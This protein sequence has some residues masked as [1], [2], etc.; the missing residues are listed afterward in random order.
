MR[1]A[2]A[3]TALLLA[4]CGA[5]IHDEPT[6]NQ[7]KNIEYES[8]SANE[9]NSFRGNMQLDNQKKGPDRTTLR[10]PTV[11][12]LLRRLA[13]K[14]KQRGMERENNTSEENK[15][16]PLA[17]DSDPASPDLGVIGNRYRDSDGERRRASDAASSRAGK[18]SIMDKESMR[19]PFDK[20]MEDATAEATS[21]ST[22]E[23]TVYEY[24]SFLI[25]NLQEICQEGQRFCDCENFDFE[26]VNGTIECNRFYGDTTGSD[27]C[28]STINYCGEPVEICYRETLVVEASDAENYSYTACYTYTAP[29]QQHVCIKFDHTSKDEVSDNAGTAPRAVVNPYQPGWFSF[30]QPSS[31]PCSV[32]FNNMECNSCSSEVRTYQQISTNEDTGENEIVAIS[33][34]RCFEI[35]CSNTGDETNIINTC[36]D[37]PFPTTLRE[38]VVF[39]DDCTKCQPCGLG[40]RVQNLDAEGNFPLIGEY[41]CSG[42]ELAAKI[43]FFDRKLC[44]EIQDKA[45]EYCGCEPDFYDPALL[46]SPSSP[47]L[48]SRNEPT[49]S[50]F[51]RVVIPGDTIGDKSCDV[52]GSKKAIV[53]NPYEIVTLKSGVQTSCSALQGAGRIG[54]FTSEYCRKEVMPLVFQTCG[55]CFHEQQENIV[56]PDSILGPGPSSSSVDETNF[57][58]CQ[59]CDAE[60]ELSMPDNLVTIADGNI[61]CRT[62]EDELKNAGVAFTETFCRDEARAIADAYCGGCVAISTESSK[63]ESLLA[64]NT[65]NENEMDETDK[66]QDSQ[67]T[68]NDPREDSTS[69]ATS[70]TSSVLSNNLLKQSEMDEIDEKD[71]DFVP[72]WS[73]VEEM[74]EGGQSNLDDTVKDATST[75]ASEVASLLDNNSLEQTHI[76]DMESVRSTQMNPV[77]PDK[78]AGVDII[79]SRIDEEEDRKP[80]PSSGTH[81]EL[82]EEI[83]VGDDSI[84]SG[85]IDK[86][87]A[88]AAS[89]TESSSQSLTVASKTW[90]LVT[91]AV[92]IPFTF[93]F[94]F[95]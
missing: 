89:S 76:E 43:G 57:V 37:R 75:A 8:P 42:M 44:T 55:G 74:Y 51:D 73:K 94:D 59:I 72:K 11:E 91:T 87:I 40:Q 22:N 34:E 83:D 45:A 86:P 77:D 68:P 9:Q 41:K 38:T 21:F 81:S 67:T 16:L 93:L 47:I 25:N 24:N 12:K 78:D 56:D 27:Y 49:E 65:S 1:F 80:R 15:E 69:T 23:D 53:A 28:E 30:T 36:V 5:S 19:K 2:I 60:S 52:C 26:T 71:R 3:T 48:S 95:S 50:S 61:T 70:E 46:F 29:Y 33:K 92:A 90:M 84:D 4:N 17:N 79:M 35:D 6:N 82:P 7:I 88:A 20:E 13:A 31:R 10:N 64:D 14:K 54:L 62:F 32:Q 58:P 39:G 85:D 18:Q 66:N 63:E